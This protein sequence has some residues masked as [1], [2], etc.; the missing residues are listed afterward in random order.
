MSWT[1]IVLQS[2]HEDSFL[3]Q[4]PELGKIL[5]IIQTHAS[6]VLVFEK[7]VVK[8]K[9]EVNFGFLD[10]STKE[11]RIQDCYDEIR[12]NARLS[13]EVYRGILG[14]QKTKYRNTVQLLPNYTSN[15]EMEA[16][17]WMHRLEE[18]FSWKKRLLSARPSLTEFDSLIR[19]LK[20]FY[21]RSPSHLDSEYYHRFIK[22]F[23]ENLEFRLDSRIYRFLVKS[24]LQFLDSGAKNLIARERN[25]WVK[26]CHG[27]L[28]LEHIYWHRDGSPEIIDCIEFNQ[29][30]RIIDPISD[31]SFL[32]MDLDLNG[33]SPESN[34][35]FLQYLSE[36]EDIPV[37]VKNP[38]R[39]E[40]SFK[41]ILQIYKIYRANVRFKIN[42]LR[43]MEVEL[44][45][46]EKK[47]STQLAEQYET[48]AL[49]YILQGG[50]LEKTAICIMG[51]IGTGK[52]TLA[53]I[54]HEKLKIKYYSSDSIRKKM[55]GLP[56]HGLPPKKIREEIYTPEY[57]KRSYRKMIEFAKAD[58]E[59]GQSVI[60]DATFAKADFRQNAVKE[61][62][63]IFP[64]I[65]FLET[66]AKDEM[67]RARLL[68]RN[69][70]L[71]SISDA[72]LEEFEKLDPYFE[73]W[74]KEEEIIEQQFTVTYLQW[75]TD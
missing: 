50:F 48:L 69:L 57:T 26:D 58:G 35:L 59:N 33:F 63:K 29:N 52:S 45:Q 12:L 28:H 2:V 73:N 40:P 5:E 51:K 3:E 70:D 4:L 41:T 44:S 18:D 65:L 16:A 43:R 49:R 7:S 19:T 75:T 22:A 15:S 8:I 55:A 13:P 46:E 14:L 42:L 31:I 66:L 39:M 20:D 67:I 30:F 54:L 53:K 9:K 23:R 60:L 17:V 24:S 37:D 72:R 71:D 47:T 21:L 25:G 62:G 34:Q 74:Q 27:D 36:I 38:Y 32:L 11:K 61:L 6:I 64:R 10:F 56:I 1:D 68:A